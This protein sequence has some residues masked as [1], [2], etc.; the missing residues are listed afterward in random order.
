MAIGAMRAI[1]EQGLSVPGE[2]SVIGHDDIE[3]ASYTHPALTT[4]A[5]PIQQ[6]AETAIQLLLDRIQD[7]TL[8]P[9]RY[10][11]PN[12]LILRQSTRSLL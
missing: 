6:L 4:I 12:Q 11:L 1:H 5:Q 3:W 9:R 8:P 10:T 7:P 2:I